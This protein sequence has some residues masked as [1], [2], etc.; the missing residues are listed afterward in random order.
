MLSLSIQQKKC[1]STG[2]FG[3]AFELLKMVD[4]KTQPNLNSFDTCCDGFLPKHR[5]HI[6]ALMHIRRYV[7]LQLHIKRAL[8]VWCMG[9]CVD[10]LY[11][12]RCKH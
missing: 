4:D 11:L 2:T 5:S 10:I 1:Y 9:R 3:L 12:I 6:I 7:W 8:L